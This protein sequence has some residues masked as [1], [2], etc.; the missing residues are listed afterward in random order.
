MLELYRTIADAYGRLSGWARAGIFIGFLLVTTAMALGV[1]VWLPADHF[2]RREGAASWWYRNRV[3]R[4]PV[5]IAKNLAGLTLVPLGF[6]ML[7]G[8]GPGLVVL[9]IALSLLDFPGKRTLERKLIGRPAVLR[10]LNDLRA[11]FGRP[12]LTLD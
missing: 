8:P 7:L 9:I 11:G 2:R 5:L 12:P 3:L 10:S 6:V 4:F 1:V